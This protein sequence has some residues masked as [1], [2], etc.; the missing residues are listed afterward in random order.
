MHAASSV[1][2]ENC[3]QNS[4]FGI[5]FVPVLE[6]SIT[7]FSNHEVLDAVADECNSYICLSKSWEKF[8]ELI[9]KFSRIALGSTVTTIVSR[10][11]TRRTTVLEHSKAGIKNTK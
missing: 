2:P 10:T 5:Y 8:N 9:R 1:W 4:V 11:Q 6:D 3:P 7:N